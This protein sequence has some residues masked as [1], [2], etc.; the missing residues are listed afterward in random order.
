WKNRCDQRHQKCSKPKRTR[1]QYPT[2]LLHIGDKIT[3]TDDSLSSHKAGIPWSDLPVTIRDVIEVTRS[4]GINYIWIDSLCIIQQDPK[5]IPVTDFSREG[6]FMMEIYS[7]SILT[8][9]AS[10]GDSTHV[11][12]FTKRTSELLKPA[13]FVAPNIESSF[14]YVI[15]QDLWEASVS[16][17]PLNSRGWVLQE[18]LLSPRT[19]HLCR[20][21]VFWECSEL[22]ACEGLPFGLPAK[23]MELRGGLI[24]IPQ[25]G[26]KSFI[27]VCS[28]PALTGS[29]WSSKNS[30]PFNLAYERWCQIVETFSMCKFTNPS[31]KIL[32]ITGVARRMNNV[33]DDTFLAGLW[34]KRFFQGLAWEVNSGPGVT[35]RGKVPAYKDQPCYC[36]PSWSW[37]SVDGHV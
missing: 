27:N 9:A 15:D 17:A 21:Q 13:K 18:R 32:A 3:T 30:Q 4:L 20:E 31:D 8:I 12:C 36:G 33:F 10:V 2:R 14:F 25:N 26:F 28:T 22:A 5:I 29:P 11:P 24:P 7:N 35:T 34:K 37:V 19:I 16:G 1:G 6:P 23:I